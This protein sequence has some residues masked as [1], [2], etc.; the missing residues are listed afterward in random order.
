MN[1][2]SFGFSPAGFNQIIVF[3]GMD[4]EAMK[5]ILPDN[6]KMEII[7]WDSGHGVYVAG[8]RKEAT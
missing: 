1:G 2:M 7:V 5:E 8:I 3:T 6:P 4:L